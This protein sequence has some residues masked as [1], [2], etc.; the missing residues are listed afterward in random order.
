MERKQDFDKKTRR[1]EKVRKIYSFE[2]I[3]KINIMKIG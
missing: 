2:D 1:K 3:V